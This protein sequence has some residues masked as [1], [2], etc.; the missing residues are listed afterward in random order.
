MNINLNPNLVS[1]CEELSK[2]MDDGGGKTRIVKGSKS[3]LKVSLMY[4]GHIP[5]LSLLEKADC[6]QS[7]NKLILNIPV[8]MKIV[9]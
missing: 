1:R 3:T 9:L 4:L 2:S 5:A 6:G 8:Q 7:A